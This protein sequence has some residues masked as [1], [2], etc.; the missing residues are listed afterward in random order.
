MKYIVIKCGGSVFEALPQSFYENII[1]LHKQGEWQPIIVHGGGPLISELLKK[2]GI[3]STFVNGLRV[4]TP[5]MLDIIEMVLSGTV[6]KQIVRKLKAYGGQSIGLSGVDA[7]LL[8]AKQI[9]QELGYVGQV[10]AVNHELVRAIVENGYIPVISP[11]GID[12]Q[13]NRY[14]INGDA[15]AAA[16][17]QSLSAKLCL[18]SDIPGIYISKEH[19]LAALAKEI[20]KKKVEQLIEQEIISG[21]MIPKVRAAL[22]S[23]EQ[24][25]PEVCIL[26]GLDKD[27][28]LH[29]CQGQPIGTRILLEEAEAYVS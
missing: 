18:I 13:G 9:S 16:I 2:L 24:Q 8:L 20:T 21:G 14:N 7:D 11:L 12:Q 15:A 3:E 4:T 22:D 27:S 23:L 5:D 25:V 6:N 19:T 1:S 17:A 29:Y 28:L 26:N 10:I